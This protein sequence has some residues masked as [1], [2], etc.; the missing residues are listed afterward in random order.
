MKRKKLATLRQPY[1]EQEQLENTTNHAT[2][3]MEGCLR[4]HFRIWARSTY[5]KRPKKP[6]LLRVSS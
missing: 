3:Q 6:S 1:E 2:C 4:V 5:P